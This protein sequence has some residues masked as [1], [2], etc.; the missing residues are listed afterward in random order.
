V[1]FIGTEGQFVYITQH[2]AIQHK[3]ALDI[4]CKT[5]QDKTTPTQRNATEHNKTQP[6]IQC[7][8]TKHNEGKG[9]GLAK[10]SHE[11]PR[12]H[13]EGSLNKGKDNRQRQKKTKIK[14]TKTK[15]KGK[16]KNIKIGGGMQD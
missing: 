11:I 10:F 8:P 15:T 7:N 1:V 14:K 13:R 2:N 16:D 12:C 5:V 9:G 3:I 4:Y 6:K